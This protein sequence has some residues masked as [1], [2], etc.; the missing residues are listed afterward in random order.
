VAIV[1]R[2]GARHERL[3][4]F[5]KGHCLRGGVDWEALNDKWR[6]LLTSRMGPE[7]YERYRGACQRLEGLEDLSALT[8]PL[9]KEAAE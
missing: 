4:E 6:S 3:V 8:E 2:A 5:P 7:K 1:T 9:R